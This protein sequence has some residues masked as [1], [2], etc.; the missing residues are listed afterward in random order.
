M[1]QLATRALDLLLILD[2]TSF[3][4]ELSDEDF[5]QQ[6]IEK[7][8]RV[9]SVEKLILALD[10]PV[11]AR[12]GGSWG[13][14]Q[15]QG[16]DISELQ[17]IPPN[18]YLH[19]FAHRKGHIY[20]EQATP[21]STRDQ[22]FYAIFTR[23]LEDALSRRQ[24][25]E[26]LLRS[27]KKFREILAS[28]QEGYYEIDFKG[29][30]KFCNA[31]LS[32][33]LGYGYGELLG[34]NMLN[35]CEERS[36]VLRIFTTVWQNAEP[37]KSNIIKMTRKDG[38]TCYGEV[39]IGLIK[40]RANN[41]VGFNGLVRDITDRIKYQ[42]ELEYLSWHDALTES[43]NRTY[44]EHQLVRKFKKSDYPISLII[45]DLDGLKI[46]NDS[47]G[48]PSGDRLLKNFANIFKNKIED[49]GIVARLGGDEF[50]SLVFNCD[51]NQAK[52]LIEEI[53]IEVEQYNDNNKSLPLSIS[54]GS[55]TATDS[56]YNL[57]DLYKKADDQMLHDKLYRSDTLKSEIVKTLMAALA[58][59]D[60][61]THGHAQ[62]IEKICLDIAER[63][64]LS[65]TSRNNLAL[66]AKVHDLGKVGIPDNILSKP[67]KL[68]NSE[69]N[70]MKQHPEKGYRIAT[71][72]PH[73]AA[74]SRFILCHHE[75]WDG[76]GYPLGL[77]GPKIPIECRILAIADTFDAM[78]S[79]RPYR[80]P[81]SSEVAIAEI[82]SM[83]GIQFDPDVVKE[84]LPVLKAIASSNEL[85]D[86]LTDTM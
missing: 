34:V 39:S 80:E 30:I 82:K 26:S 20:L 8:S 71:A 73:L 74:I 77:A 49:I 69:W 62:R 46:I 17:P 72:T 16:L 13:F 9:L 45:A 41:I 19:R 10:D 55:A 37:Q 48:H 60:Y 1:Q 25:K 85:Q 22:R 67:G 33:F 29:R 81:V 58:E 42:H 14:N 11:L 44:F 38:E 53:R 6:I 50:G 66:L 68:T 70:I 78:T 59:R 43:Y 51:Q 76:S 7:A 36:R 63:L 56:T 28:M 12:S 57:S 32:D 65:T 5:F 54:F 86:S 84:A 79:V 47:M 83:A 2:I 23:S 27:E 18:A 40:D 35:L 75:R 21:L 64:G 61:I 4:S 15:N 31:A 24:I 52:Q 3:D